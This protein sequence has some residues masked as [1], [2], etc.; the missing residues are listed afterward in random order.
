MGSGIWRLISIT[1]RD[2]LSHLSSQL[3][4][5]VAIGLKYL[6]CLS[7]NIRRRIPI[8]Q[9]LWERIAWFQWIPANTKKCISSYC[10]FYGAAL[11]LRAGV[12]PDRR[13]AKRIPFT[14]DGNG[15]PTLS[16]NTYSGNLRRRDALSKKPAD[17][18]T[19]CLIPILRI[20]FCPALRGIIH[21]ICFYLYLRLRPY[22]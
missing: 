2:I 7:I 11:L 1:L 10:P 9:Q 8:P 6:V 21:R 5:Y 20:L 19:N 18:F 4:D 14:S 22:H 12:E 15:C 16:V 17:S 3:P 13:S